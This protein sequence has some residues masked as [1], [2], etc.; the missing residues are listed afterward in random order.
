MAE[1]IEREAAIEAICR[2][3]G[4]EGDY[5][6]CDGYSENSDWCDYM[7]SLRA[8]PAVDVA[9]VRHGRWNHDKDGL[10]WCCLCG[11]GKEC[12]DERQYAYCPNCGAKMEAEE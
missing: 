7:V 6:K 1:Y 11:F 5:H 2:N 8:V 9:P 10:V 4:I 3:C 12:I